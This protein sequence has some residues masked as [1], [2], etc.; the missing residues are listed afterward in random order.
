MPVCNAAPCMASGQAP[1]SPHDMTRPHFPGGARFDA[2]YVLCRWSLFTSWNVFMPGTEFL[3]KSFII[4]FFCLFGALF[5][6]PSSARAYTPLDFNLFRLGSGPHTALVIGGIQGDEPGGFSAATLLATRYEI[7]KGSLWVVPNLN[8]PSIIKRTRGLHGDMNRKFATLSASDPEYGTVR[9][10]QEIIDSPEVSLV[11]NLHDGS[12]YYRPEHES[13]LKNPARWGQSIIIDQEKLPEGLFMGALADHAD[14]VA[15]KAN[16]RLL[17]DIEKIHVHNTRTVEGDHEMEKS[18]SYYAVRQNKAAFGLEASKELGVAGRAFYHLLMIEEFLKMAGLEFERD[19]ELTPAG[20]GQALA[21]NIAVSFAGNRIFLPLENA[22]PTINYLPLA[23]NLECSPIASK[24]IMAVLPCGKDSEKL[25]VH[26]GNRKISVIT[27]VW[28]EA[29]DGLEAIRAL[30][31]GQERLV[32]FGQTIDVRKSVLIHGEPGYRV[33]AIG[34][35]GPKADES[36]VNLRHSDFMPR[37]SLDRQGTI[38]RVEVYS[39]DKFAGLF[40]LR[41]TRKNSPPGKS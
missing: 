31:D 5:L 38:Y 27:P 16:L 34:F 8:F 20:I 9:R 3:K 6:L 29:I 15:K 28:H 21:E 4:C 14:K 33:N 41:F 35:S 25:C 32:R 40:L 7:T 13:R 22:R 37:F 11:L 17:K 18:L 12:G 24:P 23:S 39:G 1:R 36:G 2:P 10:I 26:Y 30:V 19:F